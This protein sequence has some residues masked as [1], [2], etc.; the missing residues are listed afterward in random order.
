MTFS[1]RGPRAGIKQGELWTDSILLGG[2]HPLQDEIGY[3]QASGTEL[4]I[5]G[6]TIF[7]TGSVQAQGHYL[8]Y[9]SIGSPVSEEQTLIQAGSGATSAGSTVWLVYPTAYSK[10]PSVVVTPAKVAA[11]ADYTLT[12][13]SIT[14]GSIQLFSLGAGAVNFY[15]QSIGGKS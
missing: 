5:S 2:S 7:I 14:T 1:G 15:W 6:T 11:N 10:V 8:P 3:V 9:A 4:V 12:T 13:G